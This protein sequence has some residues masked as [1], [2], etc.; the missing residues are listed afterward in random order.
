MSPANAPGTA[1][2]PD[3]LVAD[4]LAGSRDH[5][6]PLTVGEVFVGQRLDPQA[7]P[8]DDHLHLTGAQ[9]DIVA[10]LLGDHQPT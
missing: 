10:Q 9:A 2:R 1:Q 7:G 6:P 8:V 4:V 5:E 3:Q